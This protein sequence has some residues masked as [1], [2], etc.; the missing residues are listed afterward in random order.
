M[1]DT[2][3]SECRDTG[4]KPIEIGGSVPCECGAQRY[5]VTGARDAPTPRE[6]RTVT[7]RLPERAD[8]RLT[9]E[10]CAAL[11]DEIGALRL[12]ALGA[13]SWGDAFRRGAA[14]LRTPRPVAA[15]ASVTEAMVHRVAD[16]VRNA[17][18]VESGIVGHTVGQK[19]HRLDGVDALEEALVAALAAA[20]RDAGREEA[21]DLLDMLKD[22][23]WSID[24]DDDEW[25]VRRISG[26]VN[27]RE[28]HEVGR[29]DTWMDALRAARRGATG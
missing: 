4:W 18:R 10:Q 6:T 8:E 22:G 29:G 23:A 27:D 20:P 7:A 24:G 19:S 26:P 25:V 11:L 1:S 21:A 16:E 28:W 13:E 12:S 15:S 17:L 2:K 5:V 9:D 14:A 3:C